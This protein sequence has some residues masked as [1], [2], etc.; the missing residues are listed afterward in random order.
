[1]TSKQVK[2]V[3]AIV[4]AVVEMARAGV[5]ACKPPWSLGLKM[6]RCHSYLIT[7]VGSNHL[8]DWARIQGVGILCFGGERTPKTQLCITAQCIRQWWMA[9]VTWSHKIMMGQVLVAHAC[10][11][12]YSG[13]RDQEDHGSKPAQVHSSQDLILKKPITKK[14]WW[15][16]LRCKLWVQ[17]IVL[18]EKKEK[19]SIMTDW[20]ISIT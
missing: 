2:H 8:H 4:T 13:G 9:Y 10:H 15:I 11:P 5:E 14:G 18:P 12:S 6:A 3:I 16:G 20:R 1:M 17:T 19:K 7:V